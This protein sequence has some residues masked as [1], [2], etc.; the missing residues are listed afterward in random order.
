MP[1]TAAELLERYYLDARCHLLETA[2]F[3]D[4][5]ERAD[6]F[7]KIRDDARYQRLLAALTIL[8]N[9][10]PRTENFLN[11]FSE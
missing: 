6:G 11:L 8:Q 4:R 9:E 10:T 5:L 3:F 7:A 2:A 1:K